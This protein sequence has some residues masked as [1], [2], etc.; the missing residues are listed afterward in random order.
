MMPLQVIPGMAAST[1]AGM[2]V[3]LLLLVGALAAQATEP[4]GGW[5]FVSRTADVELYERGHAGTDLHEYKA[6]GVID[7]PPACVKRVLDDAG[8][9]PKF[10][11]YVV[12]T[13]VLS[14]DLH[15]RVSY[16]RLAPPL[17]GERDYTVKVEYT[18]HACANGTAYLN[19]WKTANELGPAEKAGVSRVKMTEGSWLLE[20]TKSGA[21]THATYTLFSDS[22]GR[23]PAFLLNRAGKTA[24]PKVF[25]A[26]RTQVKLPKYAQ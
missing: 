22:G 23:M 10:M 26:I 14:N 1:R 19:Q 9:Y 13:K 4:G 11:P 24:V 3:F 16:Q 21:A 20:P 17:V 25:S 15:G 12:E 7:A 5:S 6:I 18:T 2:F 8:E